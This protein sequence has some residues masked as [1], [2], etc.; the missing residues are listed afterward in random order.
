MNCCIHIRAAPRCVWP[1]RC[2]GCRN[3]WGAEDATNSISKKQV[4]LSAIPTGIVRRKSL[5]L[6]KFISS[7]KSKPFH[8]EAHEGRTYYLSPNQTMSMIMSGD[9][10]IS[11]IADIWHLLK[12]WQ[13]FPGGL[14]DH[15]P[16]NSTVYAIDCR[17]LYLYL[18][19]LTERYLW[20]YKCILKDRKLD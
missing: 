7:Q 6:N 13:L 5:C 18:H 14:F 20:A 9:R 17:V 15:N 1:H 2:N 12:L 19:L 3:L 16:D 11:Q 10:G 8:T 4:F